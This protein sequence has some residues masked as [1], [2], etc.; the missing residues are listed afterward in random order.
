MKSEEGNSPGSRTNVCAVCSP[1][2]VGLLFVCATGCATTKTFP[3][4]MSAEQLSSYHSDGEALA[5]YLT[6]ADAD[7]GV[8]DLHALGP[9]A[10]IVDEAGRQAVTQNFLAGTIKPLLW[11]RCE[12]SLLHTADATTVSALMS[13]L[14][15]LI[16]KLV[17]DS[18]AETDPQKQAQIDS[19]QRLYLERKVGIDATRDETL[20]LESELRSDLAAKR[21]GPWAEKHVHQ[22]L[23]ELELEHGFWQG[24]PIDASVLDTLFKSSDEATLRRCSERL[25]D[26]ALR[27]QARRR[28]IRLHVAASPF[29]EVHADPAALEETM[30]KS[31]INP[32]SLPQHAPKR[33]SLDT[34][35]VPQRT[36]LINQ[37]LPNQT[38]TLTATAADRPSVSVLPALRLRGALQVELDGISKP[39]T[40]C[41]HPSS[42]DPSPCLRPEDVRIDSPLASLDLN[43][44]FRFAS[45][46]PEAT[47]VTLAQPKHQL[48]LPVS[49]GGHVMA[50]IEWTAVFSPT[51]DLVFSADVPGST[52]PSLE[53]LAERSEPDHLRYSLNYAGRP[54]QA[55]VEWDNA[56]KFHVISRGA[57]GKPGTPGVDG[58]DGAAGI[59]GS[60]ASCPSSPGTDGSQGGDGTDGTN[61]GPGWPGGNGGPVNVKLSSSP[62]LRSS[63]MEVLHA[64]VLSQGGPGGAGGVGGRGGQGGQGGRGGSGASC[65]DANGQTSSVSGGNAGSNGFDGANGANGPV[66]PDGA[67]GP[68]TF[69]EGPN[70]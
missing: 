57:A 7:E 24:H 47:A 54:Y 3:L 36:V 20:H 70:S 28:I 46:I 29:T 58:S 4:P 5:A 19:A 48:I 13:D 15:D 52:G 49:I 42:L 21:F 14:V 65:S 2:V 69:D 51:K 31:G 41:G 10:S 44:S 43:G 11:R 6:Q 17:T 27:D 35:R 50:S 23:E 64:A 32:V 66:G 22:L 55:V 39:V 26:A 18:K 37:D 1:W 61:G 62:E 34:S 9:H 12:N 67:A 63:T 53:V 38:A 8:C 25:T 56:G 30:M 68:V 59:D 40:L 45:K 33:G 60:D 16:P